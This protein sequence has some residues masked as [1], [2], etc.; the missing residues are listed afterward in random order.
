MIVRIDQDLC[1]ACASCAQICPEI[2][3]LAN[4]NIRVRIGEKPVPRQNE[5]ACREAVEECPIE[6]IAVNWS[7]NG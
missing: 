4:D 1:T 6:A 2:F 5:E 7:R 3:V